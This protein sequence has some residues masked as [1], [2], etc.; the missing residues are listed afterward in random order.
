MGYLFL[1]L[2][3]FV[4]GGV[5]MYVA[6]DA[7]RHRVEEMLHQVDSAAK[8]NQEGQEDIRIR[9]Q[10]LH[11]FQSQVISYNELQDENAILKR[12]L[13]NLSVS[14]R[15]T[16]L[17]RD[18]QQK[19]EEVIGQ[20]VD[21]VGSRYLTE[22]VKWIGKS[23]NANNFVQCKQRLQEVIDRCRGIGFSISPEDEVRYIADLRAEYEKTVR[24][25]FQKEEQGRI[26]AQ[27]REEQKLEREIQREQARIE[28]ERAVLQEALDKALATAADIHSAQIEDLKARLAEAEA[29]ERAI[30]QA[31]LTKAGFIYVISNIGAFGEG[32][33]KIGMTRRLE[34]EDRIREL[35][36]ASVPFP[37]D[38][39]MMISCENAPT[40]ENV[41]HRALYKQQVNKT[42]PRKEFF[43]ADIEEIARL[44]RENHGDVE[45]VADAEA[46][47]YR[48]SQ[49]M[50]GEDLQYIERVF[51]EL[52]ADDGVYS[53][54][55]SQPV[56]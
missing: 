40:L 16:Q 43:R 54:D 55:L 26:K 51:E 42:N 52:E 21:E 39:H 2:F 53:E 20:K 4:G 1:T 23:L 56:E 19:S 15:K 6:L 18:L 38:I 7:K 17:D 14:L 48:Q 29:K 32:V 9:E 30:S 33:Y 12:D 24:A 50:S 36:D 34:P 46:L 35:G 10:A 37:F 31:Q 5:A 44:V 47:Q 11:Q 13:R 3:G 41:L 8:Q 49:E 25:A 28:R 45:Y 22:N 27:I